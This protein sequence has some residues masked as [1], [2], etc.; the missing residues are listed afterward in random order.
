[1]WW[2]LSI[3]KKFHGCDQNYQQIFFYSP[4]LSKQ[5][6]HSLF[7]VFLFRHPCQMKE[8]VHDAPTSKIFFFLWNL[9][10]Y[11]KVQAPKKIMPDFTTTVASEWIGIKMKDPGSFF[12]HPPNHAILMLPTTSCFLLKTLAKFIILALQTIRARSLTS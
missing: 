11:L 1:M 9:C 6:L 8:P 7:V 10:A 5:C 12:N 3:L 2:F 4:R